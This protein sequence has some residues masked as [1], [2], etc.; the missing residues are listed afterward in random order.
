MIRTTRFKVECLTTNAGYMTKDKTGK[1]TRLGIHHC[2]SKLLQDHLRI[3]RLLR[4]R[5]SILD[6]V[7]IKNRGETETDG[8]I[9]QVST[10]K[11]V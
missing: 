7:T 4:D 1:G 11:N 10:S 9:Q 6:R 8:K 2:I 3:K 5:L